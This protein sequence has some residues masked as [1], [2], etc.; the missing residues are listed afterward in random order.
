[1]DGLNIVELGNVSEETRGTMIFGYS[2]S[3]GLHYYWP[4]S[5]VHVRKMS[6][7]KPASDDTARCIAGTR[8]CIR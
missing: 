6:D 5:A 4:G 3:G 7:V 1:M 2:D 8:D